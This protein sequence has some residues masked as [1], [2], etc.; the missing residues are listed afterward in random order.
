M[1]RQTKHI[2]DT[3]KTTTLTLTPNPP[4]NDNNSLISTFFQGVSNLNQAIMELKNNIELLAEIKRQN[5]NKLNQLQA[6]LTTPSQYNSSMQSE[7]RSPHLANSTFTQPRVSH[8]LSEEG[9]GEN[10][11][12]QI[13]YNLHKNQGQ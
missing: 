13:L 8:L 2:E 9:E 4:D 5:E 1:Q 10:Q 11:A 3:D 12:S 7:E 6:L